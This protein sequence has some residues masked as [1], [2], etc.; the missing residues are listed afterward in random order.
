MFT[1]L[2]QDV[3]TIDRIFRS[4]NHVR[5]RINSSFKEGDMRTG[6]SINVNGACL[7]VEKWDVPFLEA[8]VSRETMTRTNL[9]DL[10]EGEKVNLELAMRPA[11]R[12]GGH[13]VQGHVDSTGKVRSMTKSGDDM[14]L[15]ISCP[16]S[17]MGY[18]VDKGSIS[19]NGV[20][21][22]VSRMGRGWFELTLIPHTLRNTNLQSLRTGAR[23]NIETDIIG[24]Y[25]K[26][27]QEAR[28]R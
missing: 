28:N 14:I 6:D 18:I 3:G 2:V 11:D 1:G 13:I 19:I 15:R 7:T 8:H 23:V 26:K 22:T 20:S 12:F 16:S 25:I 21:L 9:P 4:G 10:R 17:L 5:L 24:K 27:L